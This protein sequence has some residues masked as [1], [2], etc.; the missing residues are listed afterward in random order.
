MKKLLLIPAIL[1]FSCNGTGKHNAPPV[2]TAKIQNRDTTET[3]EM[4]QL[5]E[6]G[7]EVVDKWLMIGTPS[8]TVIEKLGKPV[9]VETGEMSEVSGMYPEVWDFPDKGIRLAM[10]SE[11]PKSADKIVGDF[12]VYGSSASKTSRNI[13]VGSSRKE[14]K[15]AYGTDINK[16]ESS[17][18]SLVAGSIYG[19]VIFT[20][21]NDKVSE[22]FVGAAA[23]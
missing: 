1:A 18:E 20:M 5:Y 14:V 12:S 8:A 6:P 9:V 21:D 13:G 22:I 19:G 7:D 16:D 3:T 4:P 17:D 23:E 11:D 15:Q 10:E 2:E